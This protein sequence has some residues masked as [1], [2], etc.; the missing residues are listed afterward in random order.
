MIKDNLG[1]ANEKDKM[2][3][4]GF[5]NMELREVGPKF[6]L[7]MR[8]VKI[9]PNDQFKQACKQPKVTNYDKQKVR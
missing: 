4:K 7:K 1:S 2:S 6:T 5:G 8:R 9:A 3:N